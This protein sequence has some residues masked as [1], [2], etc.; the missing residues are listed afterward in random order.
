MG[1]PVSSVI[2]NIYI[3]HFESLAILT[4]STFI[5]WWC[6][7]VD[8]VHSGTRKDQVNQIQEQLTP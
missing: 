5:K 7:Y 2:V 6:R 4:F 3:E 1:F 8:D